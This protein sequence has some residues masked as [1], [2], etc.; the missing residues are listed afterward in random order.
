M[1]MQAAWTRLLVAEAASNAAGVDLGFCQAFRDDLLL[2]GYTEQE[3]PPGAHIDTLCTHRLYPSNGDKPDLTLE[4]PA[5]NC[6]VLWRESS[7]PY[8]Q[9]RTDWRVRIY[10]RAAEEPQRPMIYRRD[11]TPE[12]ILWDVSNMRLLH[13][14]R[15]IVN[16]DAGYLWGID[17]IV[18]PFSSLYA[19][20]IYTG[21]VSWLGKRIAY[22]S[23][24]IIMLAYGFFEN[25]YHWIVDFLTKLMVF[26]RFILP[27]DAV[28]AVAE[29]APSYVA[30]SLTALGWGDRILRIGSAPLLCR[31]VL[32]PARR[33][34]DHYSNPAHIAW[35]RERFGVADAPQG[36]AKYY[37]SRAN[38]E[39]RRAVN[40]AEVTAFLEQ[41]G[42]I[43][44]QTESMSFDEQL[45][46]FRDARAIVGVHGAGLTNL[47]FAPS[48]AAILELR[49]DFADLAQWMTFRVAY[50]FL[51]NHCQH[52]HMFLPS[53][54]V[55]PPDDDQDMMI[56]L[57]D[58]DRAL[59]MLGLY[60]NGP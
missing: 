25:Y 4:A 20:K 21:T 35:L 6:G 60:A 55:G 57:G 3:V 54:L 43:T 39:R 50:M 27:D 32:I 47:L 42:F 58:L 15:L 18:T 14:G 17:H 24:P 48:G 38:A 40:D 23:R 19:N 56:D 29:D 53:A 41:R 28:I 10:D 31:R 26:D 36:H 13:G 8:S 2:R 49:G 5:I 59:A 9:D 52:N 22:E 11:V 33:C 16:G 30:D 51:C 44:I 12:Q 7:P 34:A 37:I 46:H 45:R 1:D